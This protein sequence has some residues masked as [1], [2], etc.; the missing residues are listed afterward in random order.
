MVRACRS[1]RARSAPTDRPTSPPSSRS[2]S[3]AGQHSASLSQLPT[4][5][6]LPP[7]ASFLGQH[8]SRGRWWGWG[9]KCS[10]ADWP[11]GCSAGD[12]QARSSAQML[13]DDTP[14]G[15]APGRVALSA[16]TTATTR[17]TPKPPAVGESEALARPADRQRHP[18]SWS[19]PG[20]F[21]AENAILC[22]RTL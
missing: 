10:S 15:G 16:T 2:A 7:A 8:C 13:L 9:E 21:V 12:D 22:Q 11:R 18:W 3:P 5:G 20:V 17:P 14:A 6:S 4:R 19:A 1:S